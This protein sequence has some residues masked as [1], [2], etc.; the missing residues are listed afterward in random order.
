MEKMLTHVAH[1]RSW[2]IL[3]MVFFFHVRWRPFSRVSTTQHWEFPIEIRH[4]LVRVGFLCKNKCERN[5]WMNTLVLVIVST[6]IAAAGQNIREK[7]NKQLT[8]VFRTSNHFGSWLFYCKCQC[9]FSVVIKQWERLCF[10]KK[11]KDA[12]C[13]KIV[14]CRVPSVQDFLTSLESKSNVPKANRC[15]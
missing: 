10:K 13:S 9:I 7:C 11:I 2:T 6:C 1:H 3:W 12:Q 14:K 15:C 8:P 5:T 4:L